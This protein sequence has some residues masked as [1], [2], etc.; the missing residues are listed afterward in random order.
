MLAGG[1]VRLVQDGAAATDEHACGSRSGAIV[2]GICNRMQQLRA[3]QGKKAK[4]ELDDSES[5][6]DEEEAQD[7][8][9]EQPAVSGRTSRV[10]RLVRWISVS[11]ALSRR[12]RC[13][14]A[15][16]AKAENLP[17]Q[18]ARSGIAMAVE[19]R[20]YPV[21]CGTLQKDAYPYIK[22]VK[23]SNFM[24]H[25]NFT[26][27]FIKGWGIV[28]DLLSVA[29]RSFYSAHVHRARARATSTLAAASGPAMTTAVCHQQVTPV[30]PVQK[31]TS[32][33][34]KM[35][36]GRARSWQRSLSAWVRGLRP[37]GG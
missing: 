37:R 21:L 29:Q 10:S 23:L 8:A 5:E 4:V 19:V 13:A 15:A 25:N 32:S 6:D 3:K 22:R 31:S 11:I 24:C 30:H 28:P 35:A 26:T 18:H 14:N 7:E 2:L 17:A 27:D 12:V 34:A 9:D 16:L 36:L 20:P 1:A 33:A